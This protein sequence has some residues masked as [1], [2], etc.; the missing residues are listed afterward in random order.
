MNCLNFDRQVNGRYDTKYLQSMFELLLDIHKPWIL[1]QFV[2]TRYSC[3]S[4]S[5]V[6]FYAPRETNDTYCEEYDM[7]C[8]TSDR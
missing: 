1:A 7:K 3:I 8:G 6:L 4:F 2:T 5:F